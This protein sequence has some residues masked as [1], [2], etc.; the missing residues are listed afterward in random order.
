MGKN[1]W[2]FYSKLLINL[3]LQPANFGIKTNNPGDLYIYIYVYIYIY[4]YIVIY[5]YIF[6][7]IYAC[8]DYM[9][10]INDID[11]IYNKY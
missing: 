9:L 3:L 8:I 11:I 5:V 10:H 7:Y 1:G 2:D 4:M 6:I